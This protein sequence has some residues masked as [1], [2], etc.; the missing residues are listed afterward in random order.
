MKLLAG[1]SGIALATF[2]GSQA[3]AAGT[4]SG[5]TIT[6]T[7]TVNY[8]VGGVAQT[9]ATGSNSFTVDRKVALTVAEVGSTTTTVVPGQ[10]AAVTTYTVTNTSNATIDIGL[11]AAQQAGGTASHG[12]TDVFD[13]TGLAMYV[14]TNGNGTYDAGT[15]T[16]VTY[17]DELAADASKTVFIVGN[18]PTTVTNG[19]VAGV[20]LTATADEGGTA[21]TQGAVITATS[22]ANTAGVDTVLA[23]G[24]SGL[25]G[26][27]AADGKYIARDDYTVSSA[28]ITVT[29]TS[30]IVSDPINGT[31]NPKNIPGATIRYCIQVAN[32]GGAAA[33]S[34][35]ITDPLPSQVTGTASSG[36]L[37][38]TVT[39]GVCN[40]DGTAG[41]TVTT[42]SA[43]GTIASI[44]AGATRTFY[45]T[46]TIN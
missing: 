6:N 13:L 2:A 40:T 24:T 31:T 42:T 33:T 15:D 7:A 44:A 9:P 36:Y 27:A 29:K 19:Q 11:A 16:A 45:F 5:S 3:Y 26:D 30:T 1:A 37:N 22:G 12:G 14:D 23:D 4:A 20:T 10:T 38:G 28:T 41:G 8:Q 17:L 35:A 46:A 43:S 34:V 25:A 21:G 32:T 39:S 18:I